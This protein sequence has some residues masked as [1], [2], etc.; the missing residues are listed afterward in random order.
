MRIAVVGGGIL[1]LATARLAATSRPG[2][3]VVVLE[4]EDALARHQTGHNSGVVHAGL[5]YAPGSLKARLCTRGRE[6]MKEFCGQKGVVYDEC[7]KVVVATR[8]AEVPPL[9]RLH[10]RA[11]TNRVPGLR[12]LDAAELAEVEPHVTGVAGLHSPHT[13]IVDFVAVAHAM[14]DDLRA[15]GGEIRTGAPV[16]RVSG[17]G[18]R[19]RVEL[20]SGET[21]EAD[22]VIVCAGL[23]SD[24]LAR[25]SGQ[26]A[27]PRIVP[28]RGEYFALAPERAHLVRGLIYP[29]PDPALPFL[30]VHLT[31]RFDGSVWL[32]P[33]A[34]PATALEGYRRRTVV[35]REL[36]ETLAWPGT[37]RMIRRHW[38]AGAGELYRSAR[39]SAFIAELQ[40][41]VPELSEDDA[42][43]APAGV[44]AQAVDRDGSLVDDF[45]LGVIDRVVWVRNAPSPAATSSLAI[46]E[47]LVARLA[48]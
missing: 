41:Y 43:P 5:Y 13:A 17:H 10:E 18:S 36:F 4:K 44:R 6:L 42:V 21:L 26:D 9:R 12:W 15:C 40:R 16:A 27:E 8:P 47:E 2:D 46:A 19:P 22:R 28:F 32:G 14:A 30:G 25:A 24:R 48:D 11:A 20:H 38:R 31:R 37:R 45:R 1:G 7:G 33:N 3:E 23:Q 29:V 39:K 34:V 35:W